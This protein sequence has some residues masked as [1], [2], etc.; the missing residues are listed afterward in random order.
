[1]QHYAATRYLAGLVDDSTRKSVQ[2][3]HGRLSAAGTYQALH[4]FISYSQ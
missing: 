2:A 3:M 4:H 1:M